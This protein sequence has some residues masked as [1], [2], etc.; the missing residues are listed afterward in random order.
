MA[1]LL[2]NA[3]GIPVSYLPLSILSWQESIKYMVLEKAR[4]LE[5]YDDWTVHS[6]T[7]SVAVPAVMMLLEYE[8]RKATLRFSKQNIFLRDGYECQYCGVEVNR[9]TATLDHVLPISKGGKSVWDNC[10]TACGRCN[11]LKGN[12]SGVFPKVKPYKPNYFALVEKRKKMSYDLRHESWK[13]Y[14]V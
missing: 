12:K 13:N 8:K 4:V 2:L 7:W 1:T 3:D 10:T 6:P 9:K 5:S 11:A 14:L